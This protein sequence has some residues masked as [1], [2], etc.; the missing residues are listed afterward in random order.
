MK[1]AAL[2]LT[3]ITFLLC[4]LGIALADDAAPSTL[5]GE[6]RWDARSADGDLEAVF[7]PTGDGAWDVAFHFVF[8]EKAHIYSGTAVGSL[9]EGELEGTVFNETGKREFTFS[10][11]FNDG[12][13][14]GTHAEVEGGKPIPTGT[15]KLKG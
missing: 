10:G 11:S 4:S 7:T 2:S 13:F 12:E 8:R 1:R 15:L 6:Y 14:S 5:H 3:V 9:T